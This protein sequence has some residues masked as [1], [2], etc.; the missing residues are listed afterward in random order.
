MRRPVSTPRH[1]KAAEVAVAS[2]FVGNFVMPAAPKNP[3]PSS[4]KGTDRM[5]MV[6]T[7]GPGPSVDLLGPGMPVAGGVGEGRHGRSQ[8]LVACAPEGCDPQLARLQRDRAHPGIGGERSLGRVAPS[9]VADLSDQGR[10]ADRRPGIT[11]QRPE[12]LR[13]GMNGERG[14][15]LSAELGDLGNDRA[16]GRHQAEHYGSASALLYGARRCL[17]APP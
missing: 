4:P 17:G 6:L 8:T 2:R 9:A 13:V 10:R 5:G 11:K 12:D 16:E 1:L 15:D 7:S 3:D 14:A